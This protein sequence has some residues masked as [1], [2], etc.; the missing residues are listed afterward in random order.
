[1][2]IWF[3]VIILQSWIACFFRLIALAVSAHRVIAVPAGLVSLVTITISVMTGERIN[4]IIGLVA[5]CWLPLCGT[6][7]RS[8][9]WSGISGNRRDFAVVLA[10]PTREQVCRFVIS[11]LPTQSDSPYLRV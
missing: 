8:L 2:A 10:T 1:M 5:E 3:R 9:D 4:F 6:E 11:E 7:I